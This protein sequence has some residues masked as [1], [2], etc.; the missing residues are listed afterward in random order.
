MED[1]NTLLYKKS[2]VSVVESAVFG[3]EAHCGGG[4]NYKVKDTTSIAYAR[5]R[6]VQ[7]LLETAKGNNLFDF[8]HLLTSIIARIP[9]GYG[10]KGMTN[11]MPEPDSVFNY[12]QDIHTTVRSELDGR[13]SRRK[14]M[15]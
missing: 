11:G 8:Y 10:Y 4:I 1:P 12:W 3:F 6:L 14:W 9:G 2:E 15:W 5:F 7:F 13:K